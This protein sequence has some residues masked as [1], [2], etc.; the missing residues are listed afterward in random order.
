MGITVGFGE[1]SLNVASFFTANG[2]VRFAQ[3]VAEGTVLT[4]MEGETDDLVAAGEGAFHKALT[5]GAITDPALA[6]VFPCALRTILLGKRHHEEIFGIM[7]LVPGVPVAGFYSFGEQGLF[8][9][10]QNRHNNEVIAVLALGRQPNSLKR[11]IC[12]YP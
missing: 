3:P 12:P 11:K 5:R 2:G 7:N 4:V 10:G 9:D 1:Y 8:D 6:L